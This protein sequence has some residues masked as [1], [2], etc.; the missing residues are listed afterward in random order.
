MYGIEHTRWDELKEGCPLTRKGCRSSV[1]PLS[2]NLC[3]S[4]PVALLGR[5]A[6]PFTSI[7][8]RVP[9]KRAARGSTPGPRGN[10]ARSLP[11]NVQACLLLSFPAAH[12]TDT[13]EGE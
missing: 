1:H 7:T 4:L 3:H 6:H 2:E 8:T 10:L 5:L 12:P 11:I 13:A 9:D